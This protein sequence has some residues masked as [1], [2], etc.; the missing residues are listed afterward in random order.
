[1]SE[2]CAMDANL[3]QNNGQC[4]DTSTDRK[5]F[6]CQCSIEYQGEF[7]EKRKTNKFGETMTS[8]E[9]LLI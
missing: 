8:E 6:R 2:P 4:I 7:C 3:C 5:G 9:I 1:M